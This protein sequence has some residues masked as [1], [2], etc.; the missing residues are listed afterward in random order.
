[1]AKAALHSL[2]RDTSNTQKQ[3][4]ECPAM[5]LPIDLQNLSKLSI[6]QISS[7]ILQYRESPL[8]HHEVTAIM[9]HVMRHAEPTELLAFYSMTGAGQERI[10]ERIGAQG[11]LFQVAWLYKEIDDPTVREAL[12]ESALIRF[13]QES[14]DA[15][16]DMQTASLHTSGEDEALELDLD[17]SPAVRAMAASRSMSN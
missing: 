9:D 7:L 10:V 17:M 2:A 14:L 6:P 11:S 3:N 1:M 16:L 15:M 4:K 5:D 13:D 8:A 12:Y